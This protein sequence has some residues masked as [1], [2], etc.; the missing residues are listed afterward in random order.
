M[1]EDTAAAAGQACAEG[2]PQAASVHSATTKGPEQPGAPPEQPAH[3]CSGHLSG[4]DARVHTVHGWKIVAAGGLCAVVGAAEASVMSGGRHSARKRMST[5]VRQLRPSSG[6]RRQ[7]LQPEPDPA[8]SVAP[9]REAAAQLPPVPSNVLPFH[10][11]APQARRP[12]R[13][14]LCWTCLCM[15]LHCSKTARSDCCV[16]TCT[17]APAAYAPSGSRPCRAYSP[18]PAASADTISNPAVNHAVAVNH[19][20]VHSRVRH[21]CCL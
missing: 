9:Q 1:Q 13:S 6:K 3:A 15:L 12:S 17:Q 2:Q 20:E 18:E 21:S 19:A 4:R 11:P 10:V 7:G 8:V 14:S 5:A 16:L